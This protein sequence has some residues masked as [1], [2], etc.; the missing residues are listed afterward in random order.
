MMLCWHWYWQGRAVSM[1]MIYHGF[2]TNVALMILGDVFCKVFILVSHQKLNRNFGHICR[3]LFLLSYPNDTHTHNLLNMLC[4]PA[5]GGMH[6]NFL[7]S[8]IWLVTREHLCIPPLAYP[9]S[10]SCFAFVMSPH[11]QVMHP[12][13]TSPEM[14]QLPTCQ[15]VRMCSWPSQ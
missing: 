11:L 4:V 14:Q 8:P 15:R 3:Q 9:I 2:Q 12:M 10:H 7:P 1:V 6:T 5:S 13:M